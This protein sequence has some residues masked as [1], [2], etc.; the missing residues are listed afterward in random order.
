MRTKTGLAPGSRAPVFALRDEHG[1]LH[2]RESFAGKSNVVLIFYPGD[3]TPGC[4]MQL[5]AVRDE[6]DKFRT[7]SAVVLG[8]N[9][10]D[11]DSHRRFSE[12]YGLKNPLLVDEGRRVAKLYNAVGSLAGHEVTTR[13]VVII[14]RKGLIQYYQRG[15]PTNSELF[16]VLDWVNKQWQVVSKTAPTTPASGHPSSGRRGR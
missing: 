7:R 11:A 3:D 1:N 14:D 13:T 5:C 8:I 4:T 10:A 15:L 2:D 6:I 9:Q 12:T 16:G